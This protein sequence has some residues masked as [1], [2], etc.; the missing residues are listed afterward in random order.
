M[1]VVKYFNSIRWDWEYWV[2]DIGK[3]LVFVW[4][5]FIRGD[6]VDL[7]IIF[8]NW[9]LLIWL[10]FGYF[11]SVGGY[12][13][14]FF[15]VS[16]FFCDDWIWDRLWL[17]VYFIGNFEGFDDGG[18]DD[19]MLFMVFGINFDLLWKKFEILF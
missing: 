1:F 11:F 15:I 16:G 4:S 2:Y 18:V 10:D 19:I 9:G 13:R 7:R 6:W 12:K 17:M 8:D 3:N 5:F 14:V